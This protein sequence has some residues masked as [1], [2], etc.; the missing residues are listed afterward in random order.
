MQGEHFNGPGL[1]PEFNT[2]RQKFDLEIK[3]I[4]PRKLEKCLFCF[5]L[6]RDLLCS[7]DEINMCLCSTDLANETMTFFFFFCIERKNQKENITIVKRNSNIV[8]T[9]YYIAGKV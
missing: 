5:Y 8:H 4:A 1:S 7:W 9:Q 3:K 2:G 6:K